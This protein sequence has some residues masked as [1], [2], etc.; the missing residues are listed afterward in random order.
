MSKKVMGKNNYSQL[1]KAL[2]TDI[3]RIEDAIEHSIKLSGRKKKDVASALGITP[4][5]LS[6]ALKGK[7]E[8]KIT[9][10]TPFCAAVGNHFLLDFI[11]RDA[12]YKPIDNNSIDEI[13]AKLAQLESWQREMTAFKHAASAAL[14][15]VHNSIKQIPEIS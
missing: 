4:A 15:A 1:G 7:R 9:W 14:E 2:L 11:N 13:K 3:T 8:F 12:A 10:I 6:M 5:Y